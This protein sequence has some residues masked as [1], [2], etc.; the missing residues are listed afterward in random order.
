MQKQYNVLIS[1]KLLLILHKTV[2]SFD[3][4]ILKIYQETLL[5]NFLF[6]GD[7]NSLQ[8]DI[9]AIFHLLIPIFED[10]TKLEKLGE[11]AM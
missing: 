3:F 9:V 2:C 7:E 11:S 8:S 1:L 4:L 6:L 5:E 10:S